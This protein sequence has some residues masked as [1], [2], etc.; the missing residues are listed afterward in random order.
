MGGEAAVELTVDSPAT[1]LCGLTMDNVFD[2]RVYVLQYDSNIAEGFADANLVN[3]L[4]MTGSSMS[5]DSYGAFN[6][7]VCS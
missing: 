2:M 3:F 5:L 7:Q 4:E 6:G 1:S